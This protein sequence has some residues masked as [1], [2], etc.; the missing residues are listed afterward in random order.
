MYDREGTLRLVY[1]YFE[2]PGA[3]AF[4]RPV[5]SA[6]SNRILAFSEEDAR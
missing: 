3:S 2:L 6:K 4:L 5:R 1:Q